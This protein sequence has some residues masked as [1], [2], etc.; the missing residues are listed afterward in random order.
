MST[1]A[2]AGIFSI[3]SNRPDRLAS[4]FFPPYLSAGVTFHWGS[5]GG[6]MQLPTLL[7]STVIAF[8][9]VITTALLQG[10]QAVN[11]NFPGDFEQCS[12][13]TLGL[14]NSSGNVTIIVKE[15]GARKSVVNV[16]LPTNTSSWI[17]TA[18]DI[19]AGDNFTIF[20]TDSK[21]HKTSYQAVV[22]PS[23]NNDTTCLPLPTKKGKAGDQSGGDNGGGGM[24]N[25]MDGGYDNGI[26]QK[27]HHKINTAEVSVIAGVLGGLLLSLLALI[28]LMCWRRRRESGN[29]EAENSSKDTIL[30]HRIGVMGQRID[31]HQ[32]V[33]LFGEDGREEG[34][35]ILG[36]EG[37]AGWSYMSRIV[38]GLQTTPFID[39]NGTSQS[40]NNG[41][42]GGFK[43]KR[44]DHESKDGELPSY[45]VSEYEKRALPKYGEGR[46]TPSSYNAAMILTTR[47]DSQG[48]RLT[49]QPDML[50][51]NG[52]I[53]TTPRQ[54]TRSQVTDQ[55]DNEEVIFFQPDIA[56]TDIAYQHNSEVDQRSMYSE[57]S[58]EPLAG[59]ASSTAL[60]MNYTAPEYSA[61]H[62]RSRS[63]VSLRRPQ[64]NEPLY[65]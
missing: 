23:V 8:A 35:A 27:P 50:D 63:E 46:R 43:T 56:R 19:A 6:T 51:V 21:K 16:T 9:I 38:P 62:R 13:A 45:G 61:H 44:Y 53:A 25:G 57:A 30:A 22:E 54:S 60:Q 33:T 40:N 10:I 39:G 41:R 14:T 47:R 37:D 32:V 59:Q 29:N 1:G 11:V 15:Q 34:Q 7:L 20:V 42:R 28:L 58:H 52:G 4:P 12:P 5:P 24:D 2:Q 49:F 64:A 65:R 36:R 31:R 26:Q 17:W 48:S 18:V 3:Q 55:G